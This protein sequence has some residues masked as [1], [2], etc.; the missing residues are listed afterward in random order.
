VQ[1]KVEEWTV[2]I[3]C[4]LQTHDYDM[5]IIGFSGGSSPDMRDIYTEDGSLNMF[6]LDTEMPYGN[7]SETMQ[8][9]GL[10]IMDLETRQHYNS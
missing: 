6:G 9:E 4:L 3:G 1:V 7:L 2:F 10:T 5:V 8:E